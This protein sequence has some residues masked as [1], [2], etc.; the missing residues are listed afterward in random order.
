M[1]I[2]IVTPYL[3]HPKCGH[4]GGVYLFK[5]I[6]KLIPLHQLTIVSF[7]DH[8]EKVLFEDL[9]SLPVKFYLI[10]RDKGA[11][12]NI[13][14]FLQLFS[15]RLFKFFVSLLLW[16]PYYVSKYKDRRMSSLI[17][18]IT[19][20][21]NFDI[22]LF[23]YTQM[24][25][26]VK[27]VTYGKTILHEIDVS[28]RPVY[29]RFKK[30][31]TIFRKIVLYIEW[32]RWAKY[33]PGMVSRFDAVLTVTEQDR[34]L[35]Q[36]LTKMDNI[37]YFPHAIEIPKNIPLYSSREPFSILFVGSY[38]HQ[39]NVDAAL[40][41][42]KEIF[43]QIKNKYKDSYLYIVGP[44]PT[45]ELLRLADKS[46][47][48]NI[49]GFVDKVEPFFQK[50][51]V[52]VAPLRFGGGVKNKILYAMANGIPVITTKIGIEGIETFDSTSVLYADSTKRFVEQICLIFDNID[53]ASSLSQ[54][55]YQNI[56][57]IYSWEKVLNQLNKIFNKVI[58]L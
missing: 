51:S 37:Y 47:G 48:I 24:A 2:L 5:L 31:K 19:S 32:C 36:W 20:E 29:R 58:S 40:W 14:R 56:S 41:I 55:A 10:S 7:C 26:Y 21:D 3:P 11:Q 17:S 27:N 39:P 49:V 13:L 22:I 4:G 52:F 6:E 25:Q 57:E 23:E 18:K 28:Y 8:I 43:P 54:K 45:D 44:N 34:L 16:E 1:K 12:A 42:C 53:I 38:L 33:E 30:A 15:L 46:L 50:C 9:K 35:L